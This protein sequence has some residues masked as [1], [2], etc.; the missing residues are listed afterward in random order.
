MNEHLYCRTAPC[1]VAVSTCTAVVG[2]HRVQ[3]IQ[4]H[5][6]EKSQH[7]QAC[8]GSPHSVFEKS[9]AQPVPVSTEWLA[10]TA[11]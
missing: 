4:E 3:D 2:G 6:P 10:I 11:I 1:V 8:V 7:F 5:Y 9:T